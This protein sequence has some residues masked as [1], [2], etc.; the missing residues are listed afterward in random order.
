[1]EFTT[2][3]GLHFQATRLSK[4]IHDRVPGV[5]PVRV[6]HPPWRINSIIA[7]KEYRSDQNRSHTRHRLRI[8]GLSAAPVA[9][10][11]GSSLFSRPY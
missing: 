4:A 8:R 5:T 10:A 9:Y 2:C 1:M 6:L 11:L 3:L 7:L